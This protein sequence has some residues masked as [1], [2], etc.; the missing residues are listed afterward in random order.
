MGVP[1]LFRWVENTFPLEVVRVMGSGPPSSG[2][3]L[4]GM[5]M[6]VYV[7]LSS[8]E[9]IDAEPVTVKRTVTQ[10]VS[11]KWLSAPL[12][13]AWTLWEAAGGRADRGSLI[14]T[15]VDTQG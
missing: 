10:N 15:S 13:A 3:D 1:C 6:D 4:L 8:L 7:H 14:S 9:S 12:P 11:S 5:E 2:D